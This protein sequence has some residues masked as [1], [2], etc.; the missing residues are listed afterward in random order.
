M[1]Q[2]ANSNL[3]EALRSDTFVTKAHEI[4]RQ[5]WNNGS[6]AEPTID[7]EA[8]LDGIVQVHVAPV[9]ADLLRGELPVPT[10]L[11]SRCVCPETRTPLVADDPP[12]GSGWVARL[13][14]APQ[15][16]ELGAGSTT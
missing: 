15:L 1:I 4:G 3:L 11:M 12:S 2:A 8:L 14:A 5:L 9:A 16:G 10:E 7:D 13:Q 6:L